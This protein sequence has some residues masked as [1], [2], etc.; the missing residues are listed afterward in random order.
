MAR[1]TWTQRNALLDGLTESDILSPEPGPP[2][3][4]AP[5][6]ALC[7]CRAAAC[8]A[9]EHSEALERSDRVDRW[10]QCLLRSRRT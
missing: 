5:A 10:W 9:L 8:Q 2:A 4:E 6:N 7:C 3:S 1:D